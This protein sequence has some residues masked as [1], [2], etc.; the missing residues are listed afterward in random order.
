MPDGTVKAEK[1]KAKQ[2][3]ARQAAG[4]SV[5]PGFFIVTVRHAK[6]SALF[7]DPVRD[8]RT[9]LMKAAFLGRL[10]V[11]KFLVDKGT[12]VNAKDND[13]NTPV[14]WATQ[15]GHQDVVEFLKQHVAKE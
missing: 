3:M 7:K 10:D 5:R 8:R 15:T 1:G 13:G 9:P 12:D 6:T 11:A 2:S 14:M 4:E